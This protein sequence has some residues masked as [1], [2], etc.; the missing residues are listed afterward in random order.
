[1]NEEDRDALL[2]RI[3][4][5]MHWLKESLEKHLGEHFK[6]SMAAWFA[7]VAA[8]TALVLALLK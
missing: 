4:N 1:V 3:E 2:I 7:T 5:D 6:I 8:I